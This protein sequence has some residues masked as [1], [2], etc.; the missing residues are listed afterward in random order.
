MVSMPLN[1][2]LGFLFL[3]VSIMAFIQTLER[4][5]ATIPVQIRTLFKLLA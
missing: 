4:A 2:G 3:G 5:F 1:I